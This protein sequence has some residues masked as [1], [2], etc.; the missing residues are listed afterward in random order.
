MLNHWSSFRTKKIEPSKIREVLSKVEI[1]KKEGIEITNFSIGRP[2][3]DTPLHIK[4]ATKK[5]LDNGLVHYG[6]SAGITELREAV[7][8][9]FQEDYQL[10]FDPEEVL[11]TVG[12]TEA[13]YVGLQCVLNPGD[14]VIVPQPMYVYYIGWSL[15]GGA[16][17][18]TMPLRWENNF[19]LKAEEV[20]KYITNKTKA[21]IINSPHNPTGQ[22]FEK[23][24]LFKIA[25]LAVKHN[26][27]IIS[28]DIYNY[29]LYDN[30]EYF[31]I[32]K[33]P[34]MK[35]RTLII[36]SFSKSYAMD[37]WR[38]GYLIAPRQIISDALKMHQHIVS[39]PNTFVQVGARAALIESQK[40]VH[41]MVD[42]FDRRRILLLSYLDEIG[43]SYVR[44]RGAFYVF[45]SVK[46]YGLTSKELSDF[47]L[48]V[49][50][51]AVV[52]GDAFGPTGEGYIRLAY[53]TSYEEIEKGMERV[54]V[55]L[56]R[57]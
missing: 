45:P 57:L 21:L 52:P 56:K 13:I 4:E 50:R 27:L 14:E 10:S 32:A 16:E 34:G 20:K 17:C 2:D 12:A 54:R 23:K 48:N 18:I 35:E 24:D 53:S 37:G 28:D 31:N 5:A 43:L 9:R 6:S 25:E 22:L 36:G 44:P 7:C 49:A 40:S 55:A 26:F 8:K 3:F 46:K 47:L 19:F 41:E 30:A 33:V 39:C 11:I 38:I 1:A 15:L 29:M 51:V 42:E